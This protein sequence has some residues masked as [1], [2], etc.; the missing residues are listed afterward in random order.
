MYPDFQRRLGRL[1]HVR[2]LTSL[3]GDG[4]RSMGAASDVYT[5]WLPLSV[6]AVPLAVDSLTYVVD[7]ARSRCGMWLMGLHVKC[8]PSAAAWA[9]KEVEGPSG[10]NCQE[11]YCAWDLN[12]RIRT[13][14]GGRAVEGTLRSS[15]CVG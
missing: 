7:S 8:P 9:A 11:H 3:A 1:C 14:L 10:Q 15:I 2:T 5:M 12:E 6:S 4:V 13:G